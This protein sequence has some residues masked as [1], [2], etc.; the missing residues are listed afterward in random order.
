MKVKVIVDSEKVRR[1]GRGKIWP[2]GE[3]MGFGDTS[4][5]YGVH[6][7]RCNTDKRKQMGGVVRETSVLDLEE[8]GNKLGIVWYIV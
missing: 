6:G 7:V 1:D 5:D 2:F 8:G 3:S 4:E